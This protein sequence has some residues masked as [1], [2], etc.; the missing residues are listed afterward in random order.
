MYLYICIGDSKYASLKHVRPT[1]SIVKDVFSRRVYK[2]RPVCPLWIA[3]LTRER[4]K[5]GFVDFRIVRARV[6]SYN[7]VRCECCACD[8]CLSKHIHRDTINMRHQRP[9][10]WL[11]WVCA[12]MYISYVHVLYYMCIWMH[13]VSVCKL[14]NIDRVFGALWLCYKR[15]HI[16]YMYIR[17]PFTHS[18]IQFI[19]PH[20]VIHIANVHTYDCRT[21]ASLI[22]CAV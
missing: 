13:C 7:C 20:P 1:V 17:L 18:C 10:V 2:P 12:F 15:V 19:N 21:A 3:G 16:R 8:L 4:E 11:A 22:V 5:E 6:F 9:S 14:C